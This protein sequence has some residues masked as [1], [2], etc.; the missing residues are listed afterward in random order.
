MYID[1]ISLMNFRTYPLLNLA[2]TP[3]VTVFLGSNG[4]GKTNILEAVDYTAQLSSHRVSN[5][6]PL[7]RV[8]ADRAYIRTRVVRGGQQTIMEFELAP[9]KSNRVRINRAAPVRAREALGINHTILFSPEDLQLIKGEPVYRR[10]FI[11]DLAVALRPAV[12]IYRSEYEKVLRQRNSL[13]KSMRSRRA[14]VTDLNTLRIWNE[15]LADAGAHLVQA[16]LRVLALLLPQ[17][18]RAYREMTDG[19]KTVE[20]TYESVALPPVTATVI[21]RAALMSVEDLKRALLQSLGEKQ[22]E[23]LERGVSLVGPHRDELILELGGIPARGFASHGE[24]WSYALALRLASWYV[25]VSDNSSPGASPI[26]LLDDVFAELD[27]ARRTRLGEIVAG[28]EQVL[29]TCAVD[30]DIPA[31]LRENMSLVQVVTGE[32]QKVDALTPSPRA[33]AQPARPENQHREP[34]DEHEA[35]ER[36]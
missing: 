33:E 21:D 19:A 34:T 5:D 24:T 18:Q 8:G 11:D 3:G 9:G 17:L 20:F 32:A 16:R 12:N 35:S 36:P 15:Q 7:V 1:H 26:L 29:I 14:D 25:H 22:K 4:V 10:R 6:S 27:T 28:A 13:L 2:L 23:E 30:T 31:A